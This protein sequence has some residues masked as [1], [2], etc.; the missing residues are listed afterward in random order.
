MPSVVVEVRVAPG[1]RVRAGQAV[2]VLESMKTETVLRAAVGGV[3]RAVGCA[4]GE[5][6]EEGRVVVEIAEDEG[7]EGRG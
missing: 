5:M 3:V 2:V 1:E 6:V 7:E 4:K